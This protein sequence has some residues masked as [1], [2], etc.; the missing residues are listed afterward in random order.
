MLSSFGDPSLEKCRFEVSL[1]SGRSQPTC[2]LQVC[3]QCGE[4]NTPTWRRA[5][6]QLLCNACG[7]RR[8]R[9]MARGNKEKLGARTSASPPRDGRY[10]PNAM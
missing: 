9:A 5:G 2:T 7:L 8:Y 1:H 10:S 3:A 4:T 6:G